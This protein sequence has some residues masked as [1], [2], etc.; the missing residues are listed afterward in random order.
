MCQLIS[1]GHR[2]VT[3]VP[4]PEWHLQ[5]ATLP[6]VGPGKAEQEDHR[7][8]R[9]S[10]WLQPLGLTELGTS[11]EGRTSGDPPSLLSGAAGATD[12]PPLLHQC[13]AGGRA[14]MR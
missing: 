7:A 10:T 13:G 2:G 6:H 1:G 5:P 8:G 11:W 14:D 3:I 12:F 4:V 9:A